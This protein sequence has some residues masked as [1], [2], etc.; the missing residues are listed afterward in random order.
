MFGK[1]NNEYQKVTENEMNL[2][3]EKIVDAMIKL[4]VTAVGISYVPLNNGEFE[5]RFA[6]RVKVE[7]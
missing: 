5:V 7:G 6:A 1:K 4:G 2:T 3:K